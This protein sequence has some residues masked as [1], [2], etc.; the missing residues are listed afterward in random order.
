VILLLIPV[1][2]LL[3]GVGLWLGM[4]SLNTLNVPGGEPSTYLPPSQWDPQPAQPQ[5]RQYVPPSTLSTGETTW[6]DRAA[7]IPHGWLIGVVVVCGL[8]ILG[9]LILL[10]V[11]LSL[12]S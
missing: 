8:W 9:W 2:G 11:G 6:R 12:L 7:S 4:R 1:A 10:I 3:L 5:S